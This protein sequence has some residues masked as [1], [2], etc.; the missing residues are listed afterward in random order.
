MSERGEKRYSKAKAWEEAQKL[1]VKVES[2]EATGY[3][4]ANLMVGSEEAERRKQV[5]RE[6]R[7]KT[8]RERFVG[9]L[10]AAFPE[11]AEELEVSST[12]VF[13]EQSIRGETVDI[14]PDKA[15]AFGVFLALKSAPEEK[16]R[17]MILYRRDLDQKK[18]EFDSLVLDV[19]PLFKDNVGKAIL[20]L[21]EAKLK[22]GTH[23][24]EGG[25]DAPDAPSA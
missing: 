23:I 11:E 25:K 4:H 21:N 7:L 12:Q 20:E 9:L 17:V 16:R 5:A 1:K 18:A 13:D 14:H 3:R 10:H 22:K 2:G 6:N 15:P 19:I 8:L 24:I